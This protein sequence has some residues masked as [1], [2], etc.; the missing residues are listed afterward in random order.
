MKNNKVI[1]KK[2]AKRVQDFLNNFD[3]EGIGNL[4]NNFWN[5]LI[6]FRS[7]YPYKEAVFQGNA[8]H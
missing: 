8:F 2:K 3:K 7:K 6:D 1:V 4:K 5:N